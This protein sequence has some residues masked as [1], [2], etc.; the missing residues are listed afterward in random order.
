MSHTHAGNAGD[1][2]K[3]TILAQTA[4]EVGRQFLAVR[5][6]DPFCGDSLFRNVAVFQ[7]SADHPNFPWFRAAQPAL[8]N[9]YFGSPLVA[10]RALSK[11]QASLHLS[12]ADADAVRSTRNAFALA[13]WGQELPAVTPP[14]PVEL[15]TRVAAADLRQ[16]DFSKPPA[17]NVLLLDPTY[18]NDYQELLFEAIGACH[19]SR[20]AILLLAWGMSSW[21]LGEVFESAANEHWA[22]SLADK[23]ATYQVLLAAFGD[24]KL[25]DTAKAVASG[26]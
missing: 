26:W 13:F 21:K 5:Y 3:H 2:L 6:I 22:V 20:A 16:F 12:D 24:S 9:W 1:F 4:S 14:D 23:G 10:A 17:A 11:C 25:T 7:S 18:P 15:C 19:Q 8:P